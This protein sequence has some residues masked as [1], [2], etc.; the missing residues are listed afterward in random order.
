MYICQLHSSHF[1]WLERMSNNNKIL[2]VEEKKFQV[3]LKCYILCQ[4]WCLWLGLQ[5]MQSLTISFLVPDGWALP[6]IFLES[7]MGHYEGQAGNTSCWGGSFSCLWCFRKLTLNLQSFILW[8]FEKLN[9]CGAA[10]LLKM[11]SADTLNWDVSRWMADS[12]SSTSHDLHQLSVSA[13][14]FKERGKN[15]LKEFYL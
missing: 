1:R 12:Y 8:D 15:Q 9:F 14:K 6:W 13:K 3:T 5:T 10:G 11:N 7:G 4:L 2:Q